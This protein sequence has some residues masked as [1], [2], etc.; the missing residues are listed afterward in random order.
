MF[1]RLGIL[2]AA[3]ALFMI[4][5]GHWAVLQ[6]VAWAQMLR[7]YSQDATVSVAIQKTFS[8]EYPC[9]MCR[10]IAEAQ[11]TEE[12]KTP[13]IVSAKKSSEFLATRS[14]LLPSPFV[15]SRD[16]PRVVGHD[17]GSAAPEPAVPVPLLA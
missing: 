8:G 10:K 2:L 17:P 6:S 7:V 4:A 11:K 13:E 14:A 12:Q 5:G 3:L 9:N 16:Y 15:T 1:R